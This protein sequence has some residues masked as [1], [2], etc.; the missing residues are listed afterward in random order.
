MHPLRRIFAL[1]PD[2]HAG[3]TRYASLWRRHFYEGLAGAVPEVIFPTNVD[4]SWARPA[5]SAPAGPT[6]ERASVSERLWDQI[7]AARADA[8]ISYCFAADVELGLVKRTIESGVPW[9]NF[10]CDSVVA[11]DWVEPLARTVSLNWFPEGQAEQRYRALGRPRLCRPYA[12]NP[13]ALP[14][15]ICNTAVHLVGFV[16]APFTNRV[17]ALAALRLYGCKVS[18]RGEGWSSS[19]ASQSS[20][21]ARPPS[22]RA[23]LPSRH[24]HGKLGDRVLARVLRPLVL[25]GGPLEHTELPGFVSSCRLVLGL[26]A[27]R[28]PQGRY[29]SYLKS[30]DVEFPGYGACY[31]TMHNEDVARAF[32][33]GREVLTFHTLAEAAA[34]VREMGADA[35]RAR[36]IGRAGRRRV[37]AEHTWTARL[38]ELTRSL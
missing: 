7:R 11:F 35:A 28:D 29:Q 36:E 18:V 25:A 10:F 38:T 14:E 33:I 8:V 16:G 6:A 21:R 17:V 12:L 15:S 3:A 4:F 9:V 2:C 5:Q 22:R 23:S 34:R 24:A 31:L 1:V 20:T 37:L 32:E 13:S 19:P 27:G 30:R 26:N